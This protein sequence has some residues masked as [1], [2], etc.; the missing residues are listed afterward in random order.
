MH[1][2]KNK[3]ITTGRKAVE[4]METNRFDQIFFFIS[5]LYFDSADPAVC[6]LELLFLAGVS[7][8]R[9]PNSVWRSSI[10][11]VALSGLK[12]EEGLCKSPV[13]T[14]TPHQSAFQSCTLPVCAYRR[15]CSF[16][17]YSGQ[18]ASGRAFHMQLY[19]VPIQNGIISA[20]HSPGCNGYTCCDSALIPW[21]QFLFLEEE[22]LVHIIYTQSFIS[23]SNIAVDKCQLS[24]ENR[25]LPLQ[26]V[27]SIAFPVCLADKQT[28]VTKLL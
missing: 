15:S 21:S 24:Q 7:T 5:K 13:D 19:M 6:I 11:G 14:L 20:S 18:K 12:A 10:E 2:V 1:W 17:F 4:F 28:S 26:V 27:L 22:I 3:K 25:R 16:L 8:P 9:G 23:L